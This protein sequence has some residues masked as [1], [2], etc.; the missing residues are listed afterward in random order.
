MDSVLDKVRKELN[1]VELD[2][3]TK[4]AIKEKISELE[5][6]KLNIMITGAT[7][8]GKSSTIN[9]LFNDNV[10]KIGQGVDPETMT[11]K[12][13]ELGNIILWDTP[14]LGDSPEQ[15]NYHAKNI[16]DLLNRK[17]HC[18]EA[19][20]DLVLVV[21]D[22]SARDMRTS[23]ELI[24]EVIIP[25]I[26]DKNRILVAINQCDMAMK[27]RGWD[28]N[29]NLPKEELMQF[30]DEKV[31]SVKNRVYSSTGVE[32]D[33]IY[34]SALYS[35]NISKLLFYIIK[36]T[37]DEK[38]IIYIDKINKNPEVWKNNDTLMNYNDEIQNEVKGS[39]TSALDCAAK[40]AVA[41][42]T[43]GT[44]VPI[45]G[46]IVGAGIGATLGFIGGLFG[47]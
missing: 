40:G 16:V 26:S 27:G 3:K 47:I 6:T 43:V 45:I 33:P 9:A 11:I 29:L 46:P 21:I 23:F 2:E 34:Y 35:Y 25:N 36:S 22:A 13:Y 1:K 42:A 32:I 44:L 5:K 19:L 39:L 31:K 38:R 15:D 10:A 30:L 8:S 20:V 18:G 4:N 28:R 12:K 7:G 17:D 24:N 14:G 37:P 41:G